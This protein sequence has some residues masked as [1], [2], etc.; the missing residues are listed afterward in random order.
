MEKTFQIFQVKLDFRLDL[1]YFD[2]LK[3][4]KPLIMSVLP[5]LDLAIFPVL[6]SLPSMPSH[7]EMGE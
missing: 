6:L 3:L 7:R 2:I 1:L 4:K 5:F